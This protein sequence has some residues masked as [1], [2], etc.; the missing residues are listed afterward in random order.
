MIVPFLAV[1]TAVLIIGRIEF[2]EMIASA[3]SFFRR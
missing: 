1:F 3:I 2:A